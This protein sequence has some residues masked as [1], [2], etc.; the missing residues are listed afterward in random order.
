MY[1]YIHYH[2]TEIMSFDLPVGAVLRPVGNG[3]VSTVSQALTNEQREGMN[4]DN[5]PTEFY[6]TA[7]QHPHGPTWFGGTRRRDGRRPVYGGWVHYILSSVNLLAIPSKP[8]EEVAAVN[9][10]MW[11]ELVRQEYQVSYERKRADCSSGRITQTRSD[12]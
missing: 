6:Y 9:Y 2:N 12:V 8:D 1:L 10:D 3:M 4:L 7:Y 5:D 11:I